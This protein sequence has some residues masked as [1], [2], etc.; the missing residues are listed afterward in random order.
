[1]QQ[2][3]P[4]GE[5]DI[6]AP[7]ARLTGDR[8]AAF[9]HELRI[10]ARPERDQRGECSCARV[11]RPVAGICDTHAGI[12][13]LDRRN[14][15]PG[16]PGCIARAHVDAFGEAR[17]AWPRCAPWHMAEDAD[18]EREPLVIGHLPLDLPGA[19]PPWSP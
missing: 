16:D 2:V 3:A 1:A 17:V 6:E 15:E 4:A 11:V 9:A 8:L 12:T 13:A 19:R 7:Y 5:L 10:E 18:D 14:I